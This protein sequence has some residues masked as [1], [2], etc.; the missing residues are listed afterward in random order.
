LWDGARGFV[1]TADTATGPDPVGS[2]DGLLRSVRAF[3][4]HAMAGPETFRRVR[5]H[6]SGFVIAQ[7]AG[8]LLAGDDRGGPRR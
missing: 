2:V 5:G 4:H 1:L 8:A 3:E 7:A 6:P